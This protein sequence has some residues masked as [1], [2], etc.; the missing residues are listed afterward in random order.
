[1]TTSREKQNLQFEATYPLVKIGPK[2]IKH[3]FDLE[4][5]ESVCSLCEM[6]VLIAGD[7]YL[8]RRHSRAFEF[9][10]VFNEKTL[11][12]KWYYN[13]L[14]ERGMRTDLWSEYRCA[15]SK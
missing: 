15:K 5:E 13:E 4:P 10:F 7:G 9:S 1:M 11:E 2:T 14:S 8:I 3:E 6:Q 12:T